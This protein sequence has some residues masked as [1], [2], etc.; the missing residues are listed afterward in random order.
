MRHKRFWMVSLVLAVLLA[1]LPAGA[2]ATPSTG[3]DTISFGAGNGVGASADDVRSVAVGDLDGDGDLDVVSGGVSG[4][5]YEVIAW[6][7]DGH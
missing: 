4:E 2:R 1:L 5:D 6:Q 3:G 7:N